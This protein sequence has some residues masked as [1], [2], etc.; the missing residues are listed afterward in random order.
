MYV[1][2]AIC[3]L[4]LMSTILDWLFIKYEKNFSDFS[5]FLQQPKLKQ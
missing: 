1:F 5:D 2:R 3:Y 4:A